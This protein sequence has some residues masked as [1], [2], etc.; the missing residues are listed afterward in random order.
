MWF[1]VSLENYGI[2][3]K[4][5][6]MRIYLRGNQKWLFD[7]LMNMATNYKIRSVTARGNP[8]ALETNLKG[9][10][11]LCIKRMNMVKRKS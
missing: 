9:N 6:Q 1:M 8:R 5:S 4:V 7:S 11:K 2:L 3:F 10:H